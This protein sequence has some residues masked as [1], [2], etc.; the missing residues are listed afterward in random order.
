VSWRDRDYSRAGYDD[1]YGASPM[2]RMS[3][4]SVVFWLIAINVAVFV[5]D[6]VLGTRANGHYLTQIGAFT[7]EEAIR[8]GQFW[9]FLTFQFLHAG[10]GHIFFNML[11]LYF[12]GPM[13]ESYLGSRR[14]LAFYL[15]CG[16][17]GAI[18]YIGLWLMGFYVSSATVKLVGASAGIYGV[19]LAAARIAPNTK[20]M[21]L[22]P[23]IPIQLR[24]M[25]WIFVGIA[26]YYVLTAGSNAGGQAAHLG[27]AALGF[28][29]IRKPG[30]L[31]FADGLGGKW[32]QMQARQTQRS[33]QRR[34]QQ[35]QRERQQ[36]DA[37]LDKVRREGLQSLTDREKRILQ[38]AT[39]NQRGQ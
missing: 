28:L 30:L 8:G 16:I 17:A 29:L 25:A 26:T 18:A 23:P 10:L 37:V 32:R 14:F 2:R 4:K 33:A 1:G 39:D 38:R 24:T 27:G 20:V 19:L 6:G 9:R 31:N 12:F 21:L 34:H 22:F 15:L 3:N 36:V 11:A 35:E 13:I 5:L 7:W